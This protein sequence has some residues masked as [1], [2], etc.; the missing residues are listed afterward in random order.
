MMQILH[1]LATPSA[2]LPHEQRPA[3]TELV[4]R[5]LSQLLT[6]EEAH[7]LTAEN[8]KK[9]LDKEEETGTLAA[10]INAGVAKTEQPVVLPV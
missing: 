2:K 8:L 10:T 3:S 9:L 4:Q 6:R 1:A 7:R 5:I